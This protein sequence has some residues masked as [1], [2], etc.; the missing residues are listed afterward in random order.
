MI[1]ART[2]LRFEDDM[3]QRMARMAAREGMSLPEF[4]V[5]AASVYMDAFYPEEGG[6][7]EGEDVEVS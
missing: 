1:E 7:R 5:Y 2:A 6:K 4:V 3:F